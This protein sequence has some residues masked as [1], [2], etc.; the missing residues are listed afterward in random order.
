MRNKELKIKFQEEISNASMPV[1]ADLSIDFKSI[2]ILETDQTKILPFMRLLWEEQQKYLQSFQDKATYHLM[3]PEL[4]QM[5]HIT[6]DKI[7]TALSIQ[8]W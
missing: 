8:F 2:I 1:S 6:L 4:F 5:F 7:C 3:N